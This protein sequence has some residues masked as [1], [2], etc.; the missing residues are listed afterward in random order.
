M[1]QRYQYVMAGHNYRMTDL[2][3]AVA[4]PQLAAYDRN[5]AARTANAAYYTERFAGVAELVTPVTKPGRSHVWHQYTL[6]VDPASAVS[7]E[8]LSERLTAAG[9]GSGFYYPKL[10]F[11]Y[12]TYRTRDD[13]R[14]GELTVASAIVAQ[15]IS[16]PVH[17]YLT[18]ADRETV[19]DTVTAIIQGK[20]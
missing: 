13:V 19:A 15:V 10:V 2:Q 4:L 9:I 17:P 8:E 11:D 1:R 7:R 18:E 3:A 16:I 6:R 20:A 5:V 14:F 12:D